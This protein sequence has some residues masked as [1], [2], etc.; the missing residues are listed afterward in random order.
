[1]TTLFAAVMS[2][3]PN[4]VWKHVKPATAADM[5]PPPP[6][7]L[8]LSAYRVLTGK[9]KGTVTASGQGFPNEGPENLFEKDKKF[10]IKAKTAWV[11]Y[12]FKDAK[13]QKATAYVI[14]TC[15]DCPE[16]DPKNWKLLGSADGQAW[17][18]LDEQANQSAARDM[19]RLFKVAKPGDYNC[20]RLEV[21]T[22]HGDG[23]IQF[24]ELK[25]LAEKTVPPPGG[26]KPGEKKK[27]EKK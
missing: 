1:M 10:C 14:T 24:A 13:K 21:T 7:D 25:L 12:Q 5:W 8:D 6:P 15:M 16:R 22:N 2:P 4:D 23:C 11:Q 9:D 18:T 27:A 20:Y 17:E 19:A 3:D 26:K